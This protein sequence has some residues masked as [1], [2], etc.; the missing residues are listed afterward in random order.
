MLERACNVVSYDVM[1]GAAMITNNHL[2]LRLST[3]EEGVLYMFKTSSSP[4]Q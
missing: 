2:T 4:D 1:E 3:E